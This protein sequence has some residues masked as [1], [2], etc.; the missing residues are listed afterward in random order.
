MIQVDEVV[1]KGERGRGPDQ[2]HPPKIVICVFTF[3]ESP[4][5]NAATFT[6]HCHK[7]YS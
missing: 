5:A 6:T 7:H 1:K 3:S 4:A 2:C